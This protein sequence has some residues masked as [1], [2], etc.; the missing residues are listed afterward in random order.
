MKIESTK[1]NFLKTL[2]LVEKISGKNLPLAVLNG[3][4]INVKGKKVLL[5]STNLDLGIEVEFSAKVTEEGMVVVPGNIL[6]NTI[7]A[8]Y[9]NTPI[10]LE[11]KNG[12]IVIKTDT[13]E[14]LVKTQSHD[15]FPTLPRIT[16]GKSF[17]LKSNEFTKALRSVWYSS[18][19]STIKPELS[20]VFMYQYNGKLITVATDSFRLAE[21]VVIA[22]K[23]DAFDP[24]LI[25]IRNIPEIVRIVEQSGTSE[26]SVTVSENQL[27][28]V[29][30][31]IYLT[32]RLVDGV[33]PDYKQIIPKDATTEVVALKQDLIATLKKVNVFS[34]KSNQISFSVDPKKKV[35]MI[36]SRNPDIGETHDALI[37]T[38]SGAPLDINFNHRYITDCFQA[39]PSDSVSLSFSG[40]GKPMV[41]RGVSDTSFLYLVMPMNN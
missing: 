22:G 3:I 11:S 12:N 26:I 17:T 41:V 37:A 33:F 20:S 23:I 34:D 15:D 4:L 35:F 29:F 38:I 2:S 5:R 18:S 30:D 25:P 39:I 28:I 40:S 6:L 24:I 10:I 7:G 8:I 36:S 21:K 1:E 13:S 9:T 31:N 32:S 19:L 27:E 14:T 16:K